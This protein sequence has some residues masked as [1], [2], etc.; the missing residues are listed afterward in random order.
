MTFAPRRAI[1]AKEI[2]VL[3]AVIALLMAVAIPNFMRA[4][5]RAKI[6]MVKEDLRMLAAAVETYRVDSGH[7]VREYSS[8]PL[9][10]GDPVIA[11]GD[12]TVDIFHPNLSTPIAYARD[13]WIQDPFAAAY[14]QVRFDRTRY[15]FH[16]Y[17]DRWAVFTRYPERAPFHAPH[18]KGIW[19]AEGSDT[20]APTTHRL[21]FEFYGPYR[22]GSVGPDGSYYNNPDDLERP[23]T[24]LAENIVYDPTNGLHSQG[25][26]WVQS[27][28]RMQ[29]DHELL[30]DTEQPPILPGLLGAH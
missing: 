12:Q 28:I 14:K 18:L 10:Y 20:D 16:K 2:L 15:T 25:N 8:R 21:H 7:W 13:A 3:L 4:R 1:S 29:K 6:A 22:I 11:P 23:L 26:I 17:E 9:F 5:T 24:T 30:G 27:D 19:P